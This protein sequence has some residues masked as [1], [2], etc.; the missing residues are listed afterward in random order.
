MVAGSS[1]C[2]FFFADASMTSTAL[3]V[4]K[5]LLLTR[6]ITGFSSRVGTAGLTL[7]FF[8]VGGP[9]AQHVHTTR[10]RANIDIVTGM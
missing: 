6:P 4:M 9:A 1:S 7:S 10:V 2:V 8:I 5:F 3:V